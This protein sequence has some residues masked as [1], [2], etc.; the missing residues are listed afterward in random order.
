ML[1]T[2][3]AIETRRNM[4]AKKKPDRIHQCFTCFFM[5]LDQQLWLKI[6]YARMVSSSLWVSVDKRMYSMRNEAI[7]KIDKFWMCESEQCKNVTALGF[8]TGRSL[9][10]SERLPIESNQDENY[11]RWQQILNRQYIKISVTG[12]STIWGF[13]STVINHWFGCCYA[14]LMYWQLL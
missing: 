7:D 3:N 10:W 8:A 4:G 11:H 5:Y 13:V 12:A 9:N 1:L 2:V 6:N 14:H